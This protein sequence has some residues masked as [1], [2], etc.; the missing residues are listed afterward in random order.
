MEQRDEN[1]PRIRRGRLAA[2]FFGEDASTSAADANRGVDSPSSREEG[3]SLPAE[4]KTDPVAD[5]GG[6]AASLPV[7]NRDNDELPQESEGSRS[8]PPLP[9]ED[10]AS[11][12]AGPSSADNPE[13]AR[14]R[15]LLA[16]GVVKT[17]VLTRMERELVLKIAELSTKIAERKPEVEAEDREFREK[18]TEGEVLMNMLSGTRSELRLLRREMMAPQRQ[19]RDESAPLLIMDC[20]NDGIEEAAAG[21]GQN[22]TSQPGPSDEA[23]ACSEGQGS[24]EDDLAAGDSQDDTGRASDHVEDTEDEGEV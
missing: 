11:A 12:S 21:P 5:G 14:L 8:L 19:Q 1:T 23:S 7:V 20:A 16:S 17:T 18:R 10:G 15:D 22:D 4:V 13:R 24:E 6:D 2:T 3:Q 9:Q